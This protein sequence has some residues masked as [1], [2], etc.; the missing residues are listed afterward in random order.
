MKF[1]IASVIASRGWSR[2]FLVSVAALLAWA[3]SMAGISN[4]EI[5]TEIAVDPGDIFF[6]GLFVEID[7]TC[8]IGPPFASLCFGVPNPASFD[9]DG[10]TV[11]IDT[12]VCPPAPPFTPGILFSLDDA[13]PGAGIHW[14]DE[15]TE[16][17][18][19]DR[20]GVRG[21][22]SFRTDRDELGFGLGNNPPGLIRDDDVDAFEVRA[23]VQWGLGQPVLFTSDTPSTG[24][25]AGTACTAAPE[26]HIY[27]HDT[28]AN[29]FVFATPCSLGVV[30]AS[31]CD[32]DAIT[33]I[34]GGQ[35]LFS[36]DDQADC[37]MDPGDIWVSDNSGTLARL[38]A[39][40]VID[41]KIASSETDPVDID[42]LAVMTADDDGQTT[43]GD[44][45]FPFFWKR[46][47]PDHAP[48]GIPDFSQDHT[49]F[50][51]TFCGPTAVADCFWWFDSKFEGGCGGFPGDGVDDFPL[52]EDLFG[53]DDHDSANVEPL[54]GDLATCMNTDGGGPGTGTFIDDMEACIDQ[55]LIIQ[56][57]RDGFTLQKVNS[58]S[59]DQIACEVEKS[60]N[61]IL[62]LGFWWFDGAGFSRC[63]GHYVTSAGVEIS[64]DT[65]PDG[66]PGI[67]GI[68]D[69]GDGLVDEPDETC[70]CT[71]A[72]LT[73]YGDDACGTGINRIA[74]SDPGLNNTE[75]PADGNNAPGL[76]R[77]SGHS[78]HAPAV[79]PPPPPADHYD[80]QNAAHDV[81]DVGPSG[82]GAYS[83]SLFGYGKPGPAVGTVCSDV[84]RW[85]GQKPLRGRSGHVGVQPR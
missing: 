84:V 19:Y 18:F 27:G 4:D 37:K 32:I 80:A 11:D 13:D 73:T 79:P 57:L 85:C 38:Y 45:Y 20:C 31:N 81:Y 72:G 7:D 14:P 12:P 52:V 40:D 64:R 29:L 6:P 24:G 50:P 3:P 74:V 77:G 22:G 58:P 59:I 70:P 21:G 83:A 75:P 67:A 63:G 16:L 46:G 26:G 76:I 66:A 15:A 51:A 35:I 1:C 23:P 54:I 5:P 65:G 8:G 56:G 49:G 69:D 39:D 43:V 17:F 82:T 68:D 33:R 28:F 61:I 42:A 60:E 62:L 34:D 48:S 71:P 36:T 25:L 9:V 47:Y 10:Y 2:V 44:P 30:D 78:R 55:W 53:T 41:M